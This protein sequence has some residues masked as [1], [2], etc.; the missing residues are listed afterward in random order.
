[1]VQQASVVGRADLKV[2]PEAARA[3]A[4]EEVVAGGSRVVVGRAVG[5]RR[6]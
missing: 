3:G 2:R 6:D 4:G 1:M 5:R